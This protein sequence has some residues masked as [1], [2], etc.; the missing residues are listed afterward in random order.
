MKKYFLYLLCGMLFA[1]FISMKSQAQPQDPKKVTHI[2]TITVKDGKK[3]ETDTV[4]TG[5]GASVI[6]SKGDKK[7]EWVTAGGETDLDSLKK[8]IEMKGKDGK[9]KKIIIMKNAG[10][11][12]PFTIR[13]IGTEGDSSKTATFHVTRADRGERRHEIIR[14]IETEGDSGKTVT[15]TVNEGNPGEEDVLILNSRGGR[16][17]RIGVARTVPGVPVLPP[18]PAIRHRFIQGGNV[19]DLSDP[20]IISYKKEKM[21]DG[22]EKITI[23]RKEVKE[24]NATFDVRVDTGEDVIVA[25]KVVKEIKIAKPGAPVEKKEIEKK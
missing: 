15:V 22:R 17:R 7:F 19:I 3:T 8:V 25:P 1:A 10:G 24:E 5:K 13:E 6:Y 11:K 16:G 2:K 21:K 20:G 18:T 23:I 14:E 4:I 12:G 9:A